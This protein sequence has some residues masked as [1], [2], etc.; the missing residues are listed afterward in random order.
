MIL[1]MKEVYMYETTDIYIASTLHALGYQV[2]EITGDQKKTF[3]FVAEAEQD[4]NRFFQGQLVVDPSRLFYSF[5]TLKQRI[6]A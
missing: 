6:Y 5:K 1:K 2:M 4:A 3:S